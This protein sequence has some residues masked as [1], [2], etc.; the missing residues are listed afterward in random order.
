VVAE[1]LPADSAGAAA[2]PLSYAASLRERYGQNAAGRLRT[3]ES[4]N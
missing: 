1:G 2:L 4:R 3:R